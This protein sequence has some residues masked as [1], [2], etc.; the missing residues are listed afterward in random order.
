MRAFV[1]LHETKK[2]WLFWR[3]KNSRGMESVLRELD[4]L[5]VAREDPRRYTEAQRC[6]RDLSAAALEALS[7]QKLGK[8]ASVL[9]RDRPVGCYPPHASCVPSWRSITLSYAGNVPDDR[10]SIII[11][12]YFC[13]SYE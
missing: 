2:Y 3:A 9:T 1:A 12:L 6:A 11:I 10:L 8:Q 13:P 4:A 5:R 7:P